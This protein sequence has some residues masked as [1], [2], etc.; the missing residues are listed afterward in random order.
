MPSTGNRE[1]VPLVGNT[2]LV[3]GV[4]EP[5][6]RPTSLDR[7]LLQRRQC[8]R[9]GG[10]TLTGLKQQGTCLVTTTASMSRTA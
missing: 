4:P 5:A 10:A 2:Y 7:V 8:L 1:G 3:D 6:E 9:Q